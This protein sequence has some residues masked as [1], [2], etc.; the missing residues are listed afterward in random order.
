MNNNVEKLLYELGCNYVKSIDTTDL[1]TPSHTKFNCELVNKKGAYK[2]DYQCN[3]NYTKPSKERLLA[4]VISD[5][6]CYESCIVGEDIDNLEEFRLM[7][8]YE[9]VKEL[10]KAYKGCKKAYEKI[11]KMFTNE[12]IEELYNYFVEKGEI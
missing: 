1:F 7:F 2:F 6:Q 11:H 10:I 4:C 9:N 8:D 3:T 5:S 12:E